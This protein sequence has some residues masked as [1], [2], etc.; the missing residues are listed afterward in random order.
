MWFS[1]LRGRVSPGMFPAERSVTFRDAAGK[2]VSV[3]VS[4][5]L[6]DGDHLLVHVAETTDDRS[7]VLLPGDVF[8][9]GKFVTVNNSQLTS[10]T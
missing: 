6:V 7:M 5:T 3:V 10:V 9:A 8:G 4:A 2:E 1:R